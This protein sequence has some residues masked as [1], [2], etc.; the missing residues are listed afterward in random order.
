MVVDGNTYLNESEEGMNSVFEI[1][2]LCWDEPMA[3]SYTHLDVYK[4]QALGS[5]HRHREPAAKIPAFED[6][7]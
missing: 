2:V 1:P 5:C 6:E 4:R 7:R 3:V